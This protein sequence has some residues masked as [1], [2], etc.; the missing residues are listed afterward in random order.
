MIDRSKLE[1]IVREAGRLALAGWPGDGH[2]LKHW[3]K[4]PGSP[5]CEADLA[6][7]AFL[8]RELSALL[9][10]AGWL[11]EETADAPDRLQ[12]Q[13]VWLVDPIDGTR[14]FIAGRTGWAISVALVNTR[15][16]L[17]GYL[18]AP[19][20]RRDEGGEFWHAEAGKGSW[21]NGRRL[22]ASDCKSLLGA[23]VPA[24]KL[25]AE[26]TDL[27]LVDQPNSIALRMAMVAADEA[28]LLATL[29]WGYEWDIA[30]AGLIAREA[31]ATVTDAFGK[32]L[33]Y[34]KH[35]PRAFGVL[36]TSSAIHADAVT[37]LADRARRFSA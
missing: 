3:E 34:N 28:D 37:R 17:F 29:R 16:P 25:A 11:S 15:R 8:K 5:V 36:V 26:D 7:D 32:A 10:S 27:T 23:R 1:S 12:D 21:R 35:D 30:A 19:V 20:R 33:N 2:D 24:K 31:G 13:L 22:V 18:Y 14:D 9:P 4:T 6:V